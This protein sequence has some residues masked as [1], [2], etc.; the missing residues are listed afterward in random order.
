MPYDR[1][2]HDFG[3]LFS[4]TAAFAS[5]L[6]QVFTATRLYDSVPALGIRPG[7]RQ[8]VRRAADALLGWHERARQRQALAELND[9]MLADIGL[10]RADIWIET[11]K[12]F[13]RG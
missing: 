8:A 3:T 13:W 7:L 12:P 2:P 11:Q 6:H 4:T 9:H 10:S 1:H 5:P